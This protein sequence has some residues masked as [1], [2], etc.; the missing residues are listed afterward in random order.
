MLKIIKTGD[1]S[2]TIHVP[3]LDENYHSVH[4]AVQESEHVF[5]GAGFDFCIADP[6]RIFEVG[7][8][9]GLNAL[10]TALR[11]KNSGREVFYTSIEKY[12]LGEE[13]V[14]VLNYFQY[15]DKDGEQ[16]F[17]RIHSSPWEEMQ[18][19]TANFSLK[20]IKGDLLTETLSGSFDLIYFDAFGPDKQ[21]DM[22]KKEIIEKIASVTKEGGVFVTYSVKGEL[23]R[24]LKAFGFSV[25]LLPGP[26]GKRQIL[27]AVKI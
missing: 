7:F 1:G 19:I 26:P 13:I 9:T 8:G 15:T 24:N 27:R 3:D 6:L 20:K 23:K 5:I 22:W 25:D 12:P 10:L 18:R 16:I 21:P 11:S 14:K 2:H 4:G 17:E